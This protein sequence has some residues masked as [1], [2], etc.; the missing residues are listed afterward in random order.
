METALPEIGRAVFQTISKLHL[1]QRYESL[2]LLGMN[3]S[4]NKTILKDK[5]M[6]L[7]IKDRILILKTLLSEYDSRKGIELKKSISRKLEMSS[8]EEKEVVLTHLG[9]LQYEVSFKSAEAITR[10]RDFD[11]T[12]EELVYLKDKVDYLDRDG[13]FN[14]YVLDTYNRILDEEEPVKE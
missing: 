5:D 14:E 4:N 10:E 3:N 6:K 1:F 2:V 8:E 7:T 13:R 12:P 9:N 11:I